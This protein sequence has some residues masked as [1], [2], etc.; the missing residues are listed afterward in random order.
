M[1]IFT[2]ELKESLRRVFTDDKVAQLWENFFT[3]LSN[4]RVDGVTLAQKL[5][6]DTGIAQNDFEATIVGGDDDIF[7][8]E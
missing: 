7:D 1:A 8:G 6:A 5:D 2:K 3:E 4:D